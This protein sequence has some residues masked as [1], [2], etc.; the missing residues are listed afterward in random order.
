MATNETL[1]PIPGRLH[2]VAAKSHVAGAN[3]IFDDDW[4]NAGLLQSDINAYLKSLAEGAQPSLTAGLSPIGIAFG[5]CTTRFATQA[6]TVSIPNFILTVG[7][8]VGIFFTERNNTDT[9]TLNINNTGAKPIL[10][11]GYPVYNRL[12]A[13]KSLVIMQYDGTSYHIISISGAKYQSALTEDLVDLGLPSGTLWAKK[14]IDVTQT[15]K[16]AL[17]DEEPGSFFQYG[18][19]TGYNLVNGAFTFDFNETDYNQTPAA[20]INHSLY[21]TDDMAYAILGDDW[22]LP[23]FDDVEELIEN[24]TWTS[25]ISPNTPVTIGTSKINNNTIKFYRCGRAN[26]TTLSDPNYGY[27]YTSSMNDTANKYTLRVGLQSNNTLADLTYQKRFLGSNIRPVKW[28]R[29]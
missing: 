17:T 21:G 29:I 12:I 15:D 3:E 2:S 23:T 9:P 8:I 4:G 14:N 24:C 16:F 6:K 22:R 19:A 10:F 11:K 5:M 27:L 28:G 25:Q 18:I 1:I 7:S 26:G 20:S 13:E